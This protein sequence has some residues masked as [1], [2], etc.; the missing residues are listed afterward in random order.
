V[1]NREARPKHLSSSPTSLPS[2]QL[3]FA[4]GDIYTEKGNWLDP[5]RAEVLLFIINNHKSS[6]TNR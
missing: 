4:V 5:E 6:G 1:T 3:L 2:K